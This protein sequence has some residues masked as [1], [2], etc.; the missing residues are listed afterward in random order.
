VKGREEK[1]LQENHLCKVEGEIFKFEGDPSFL[2]WERQGACGGANSKP[3]RDLDCDFHFGTD[4][5]VGIG[6]GV[7]RR[8][9]RT[10][11]FWR[12]QGARIRIKRSHTIRG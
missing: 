6:G 7:A 10:V 11:R 2:K 12:D 5:E 8:A 4:T 9:Q 3:L 1:C